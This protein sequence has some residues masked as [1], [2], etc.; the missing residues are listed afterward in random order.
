MEPSPTQTPRSRP[1]RSQRMA[2]ASA[3]S[4]LACA[5]MLP[6]PARASFLSGDALDSA[7]NVISWFALLIVPV[8]LVTV[9][10]LVHILPEKIAEKRRHPQLEAIKTLCL[11]SLFFGGLLWPIAWLWAYTKPTLH[12]MAWG[13]DKHDDF[14]THMAELAEKG[15]VGAHEL[16]HLHDELDA[17]E[18]RG[19]LTPEMRRA[20]ERLE[21][22][23]AKGSAL[24]A[25]AGKPVGGAA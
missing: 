10:W 14:F 9:F 19:S 11:L 23:A 5:A 3:L 1:P 24:P 2:R 4:L 21:A 13:T 8:V 20:R 15:E 6:H 17:V 12:R 22:V 7:A 18:A 25:D 16:Q